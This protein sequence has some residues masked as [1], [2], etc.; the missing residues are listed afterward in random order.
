MNRITLVDGYGPTRLEILRTFITGNGQG[1]ALFRNLLGRRRHI[2][3]PC[4]Y[5]Q[6]SSKSNR[7]HVPPDGIP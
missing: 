7:H 2:L 6:W 1:A 3:P 4:K 5:A